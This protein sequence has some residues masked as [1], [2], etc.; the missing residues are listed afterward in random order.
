MRMWRYSMMQLVLMNLVLGLASSARASGSFGE[1]DPRNPL[2]P[3]RETMESIAGRGNIEAVQADVIT[4][5]TRDLVA[6]R[7]ALHQLALDLPICEE[8]NPDKPFVSIFGWKNISHRAFQDRLGLEYTYHEYQAQKAD[9]DPE[10]EKFV[11]ENEGI[12]LMGVGAFAI[13]ASL[14]PSFTNWESENKSAFISGMPQKWRR[15][16]RRGPVVDKDDWQL[17][18]IG[19]PVSGAMYYQIARH[20]GFSWMSS[21]GYSVFMSTFF[22]EYGIES[23]AEVPS[24]QDLIITPVLGSLLGEVFYQAIRKIDENDGKLF[25]STV[26]GTTTKIILNPAGYIVKGLGQA[27]DKM[28]NASGVAGYTSVVG[29]PL[30]DADRS[31]TNNYYMGLQ[32]NFHWK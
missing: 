27:I 28:E 18:W 21:F 10:T 13:L 32:M 4:I 31:M 23:F 8:V 7:R 25:S 3:S 22:W 17:N 20:N 30:V 1:L 6:C 26:L 19:H 11:R 24:V 9:L 12:V 5:D 2:F 29:Y 16:V 14:P 15:N